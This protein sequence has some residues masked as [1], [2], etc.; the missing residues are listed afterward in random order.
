MSFNLEKIYSLLPAVYRN[1]D[2]AVGEPLKGILSVIAEQVAVLDEDLSQLYDDQFIETCSEWVVP[3]IGDLIGAKGIYSLTKSTFSQ[4][5]QVANTIA[6]RRRKGTAAVLEQ[7]A[8]DVTDWNVKVV[9]FFQL[10]A[11]TQYMNH[12]RPGNLATPDLRKWEPLEKLNTPFE[13]TTHSVDIRSIDAGHGK[14]NIPNIGIFL[15]R[16][17]SYPLS[18]SPAFRIDNRRY[19]FSTLGNDIPLYNQPETETQITHLAEPANV[20]MP[21]S[22]GVLDQDLRA[23]DQDPDN[24]FQSIYYGEDRS[25]SILVNGQE[26]PTK[27]IAVCD[28]SDIKGGKWAHNPPEG[29]E[30]AVDPVLG[31][32]VFDKDQDKNQICISFHYG[33]C[34]DI[35]GGEYP[36]ED[37]FM[38]KPETCI[39]WN[40]V[41]VRAPTCPKKEDPGLPHLGGKP[42]PGGLNSPD[43]DSIQ[44]GLKGLK[45][46]GVVEIADSGT[47]TEVP[48]ID[49]PIG[50]VVELRSAEWC[51]PTLFLKGHSDLMHETELV[52]SGQKGAEIS[53]NGLLIYGG[54]V[55][56]KGDLQSIKLQHCTLVPGIDLSITGFPKKRDSPSLIIETDVAEVNIDKCILGGIRVASGTSVN[57]TNSIIDATSE[58]LVAYAALDTKSPGGLLSKVKN[59]TIIGKVQ[60]EAMEHISNTIFLAK[61]AKNDTWE[62]PIWSLR[63]QKGCV[64]FSYLPEGSKVPRRYHCQP[65]LAEA[66]AEDDLIRKSKNSG[67]PAPS[68]DDL[69]AAKEFERG[70][71]IPQM[72]NLKYGTPSY[73]QLSL[74]CAEEIRKGADDESEMGVFHDLFQP[75]KETNLRVRLDEYLRFGLKAG[76]FYES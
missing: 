17:G 9:E 37:S 22:R 38:A 28:L 60:A 11:T 34:A 75:Q 74:G 19:K 14:Y 68:S 15:W 47:Y 71:V 12:I 25:F 70:R 33:F 27:K 23:R 42:V 69:K 57:I 46:C 49:L 5:A 54:R 20:P 43:Y 55:R 21:L 29:K 63:R 4:R 45:T 36:R 8:R 50:R 26:I 64:R 41:Q 61:L 66:K 52:I 58:S 2:A 1:K 35:G 67:D 10:L 18:H 59:C 40:V 65:D 44:D 31:R 7:L 62:A 56:I 32:L 13:S 72:N 24:Q 53:L 3:Y 16:I 30:C 39:G 6:Y 51:R 48:K 76:I 73:C